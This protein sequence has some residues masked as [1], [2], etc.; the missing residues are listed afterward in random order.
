M[1][2]NHIYNLAMCKILHFIKQMMPVVVL[3]AGV[4]SWLACGSSQSTT[5]KDWEQIHNSAVEIYN[6]HN[7]GTQASPQALDTLDQSE[8]AVFVLPEV[9][10]S[11]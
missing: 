8:T 6:R 7:Y 4:L 5:R 1:D 3:A 9:A 10:M 11:E 2:I